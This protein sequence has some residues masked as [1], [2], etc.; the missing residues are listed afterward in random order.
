M[1]TSTTV[2]PEALSALDGS[3]PS[4]ELAERTWIN[5]EGS[6]RLYYIDHRTIWVLPTINQNV[7]SHTDLIY[8]NQTPYSSEDPNLDY[9][10][11]TKLSYL[12]RLDTI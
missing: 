1:P 7:I 3:L 8:S 9:T 12:N 4:P 11:G 6:R 2:I 10:I 5:L